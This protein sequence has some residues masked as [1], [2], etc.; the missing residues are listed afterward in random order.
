M[1]RNEHLVMGGELVEQRNPAGPAAGAVQEQQRLAG[2]GAQHAHRDGAD[3]MLDLARCRHAAALSL[4]S[5][6]ANGRPTVSGS[7]KAS[8]SVIT[9]PTTAS[10]MASS[11]LP[12]APAI[13]GTT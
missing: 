12:N 6:T 8:N 7:R 13:T 11:R 1:L 3:F 2:A 10:I 4:L 5:T 9:E